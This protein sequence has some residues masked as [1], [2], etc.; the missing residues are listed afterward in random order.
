MTNNLE[1]LEAIFSGLKQHGFKKEDW[2]SYVAPFV[3]SYNA[4]KHHSAGFFP[5]FLMFGSYPR[6]AIYAY[7]GISLPKESAIV[8]QD[9]YN[10]KLKERW[11]L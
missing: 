1:R 7:L 11:C 5:Y 4:T 6:L 2:K 9:R 10:I 8:S 3:H